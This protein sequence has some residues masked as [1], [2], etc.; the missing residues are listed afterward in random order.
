VLYVKVALLGVAGVLL[1]LPSASASTGRPALVALGS[2]NV[3]VR[4]DAGGRIERFQLAR[5]GG[6]VGVNPPLLAWAP[7][8]RTALTLS[9]Q[10]ARN[11][12]WAVPPAG[13]P[14]RVAALASDV[15]PAALVVDRMRRR[16]LIV[17]NRG[18]EAVLEVVSLGIRA[19]TRS[20]TLPTAGGGYHWTVISA[21][22]SAD[23]RWLAVSYHGDRPGLD[24]F[25]LS[26]AT[27]RRCPGVAR[28]GQVCQRAHGVVATVG[29]GFVTAASDGGAVFEVD[30]AGD[31]LRSWD[32]DLGRNHMLG[33]NA[34]GDG[35]VVAAGSC[36][37]VGGAAVLRPDGAVTRV[38]GSR[39]QVC[40]IRVATSTDG[41]A[42]LVGRH[43]VAGG[44]PS[45]VP[46]V[47]MATATTVRTL[48]LPLGVIDV[49]LAPD[50]RAVLA[51]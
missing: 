8:G 24:W 40:G 51:P 33:V 22:V 13:Q 30:A 45:T 17:G 6:F 10:G 18:R 7:D 20:I 25:D 5:N 4:I 2:H 50:A 15:A 39:Y 46:L 1:A 47:D 9:S 3:V 44:A 16:A 12:L 48:R 34:D 38:P 21:A 41:L 23:G 42:A 11:W 36:D 26:R 37:Y 27:I 32:A 35:R 29:G 43:L 28:P 14:R 49:L 31:Q 19:S